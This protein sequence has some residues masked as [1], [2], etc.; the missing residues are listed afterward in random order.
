MVEIILLLIPINN[1]TVERTLNE[2][3]NIEWNTEHWAKHPTYFDVI[4]FTMKK[5]AKKW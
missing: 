5:N 1:F 2:T 3:L 4:M